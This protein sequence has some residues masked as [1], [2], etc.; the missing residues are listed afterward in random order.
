M[1][2]R[3]KNLKR[4][5][6]ILGIIGQAGTAIV[7][8]ADR[9][10]DVAELSQG[11][12]LAELNEVTEVTVQ[13]NPSSSQIITISDTQQ[14]STPDSAALLRTVPGANFSQNGLI[15]GIAQYRGLFGDRVALSLDSPPA[16]T[17]G[18][19]AMDTPLSYPPAP[20]LKDL[21]VHRGIASM[22][23]APESIGGHINV[24]FN[25]GDFA[26]DSAV[27]LSGIGNP[28]ATGNGR[29]GDNGQQSSANL[30]LV[31]AN[32][33][34]KIPVLAIHDEGE[35][36]EAGNNLLIQGTQYQ[37]SLTDLSYGWQ[38]PAT[39]AE[40]YIG[41]LDIS[42]TET[43]ALALAMDIVSVEIDLAGFSLSTDFDNGTK[44]FANI[45]VGSVEHEMDNHSLRQ[46]PMM[47]MN[48]RTNLATADNQSWTIKA[49]IP[50]SVGRLT[51]GTDGNLVDHE[52]IIS[53]PQ[54]GLFQLVNFNQVERDT[55]GLFTELNEALDQYWNFI[56]GARF[57]NVSLRAA[58][59]SASGMMAIN[60]N[61]LAS[62]FN[63]AD[64]DISHNNADLAIN[65]NRSIKQ[66]AVDEY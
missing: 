66:Q 15:T 19:N 16:L 54:N 58:N 65:L 10:A 20:L 5:T 60:A 26:N 2:T 1:D 56:V 55:M 4:A 63:Q 33:Q 11:S 21:N 8:Q 13:A 22:S 6:I 30:Q 59:V 35:D 50:I 36:S 17:G 25:R 32:D 53:N 3:T 47:A 27:N 7:E 18:P 45:A 37:R 44:L 34:H 23:A 61:N 28:S 51:I 12:T 57:N 49:Q 29:H 9:S 62:N 64:R 24:R 39:I 41:Q 14:L 43:P 52:T 31:A 42:N 48:Y 46:A 38:S 40:F